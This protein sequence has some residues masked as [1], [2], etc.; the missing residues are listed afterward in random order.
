MHPGRTLDLPLAEPRSVLTVAAL[1]REARQLIEGAFRTAWVEGEISNLSRPSSGHLYWTLKDAQAQVRCAMFR[2]HAR[3]LGLTLENG[4]QVVVRARVSLYEARGDFQL[5]VEYVEEA[6]EG[7]L[8]R[9]F[10]ELKTTSRRR[11]PVRCEPQTPPPPV[12]AADRHRDL[13]DRRRAARRPDRVL[14]R[15]F[16]SIPVLIYPTP[17]QGEA[18]AAEIER[19]LGARGRA[20]R[21]RRADSCTRRRLARGPVAV[22]RGARRARDCRHRSCPSSSASATRSTSRSRTSSPTCAPPRRRKPPSSRCPT[23]PTGCC[24]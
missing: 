9:K 7:L 24:A 4:R 18:A 10:E 17:V 2:P 12:A 6:G 16:P 19:D 15:R 22:Q 11:G 8:R 1:N 13:A 21:L 20:S 23:G 3:G 14:R 5:L